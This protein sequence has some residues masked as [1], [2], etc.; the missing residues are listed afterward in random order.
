MVDAVERGA[1][2]HGC[3]QAFDLVG[4]AEFNNA[5]YQEVSLV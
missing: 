5:V 4:S 1:E 2:V 3:H